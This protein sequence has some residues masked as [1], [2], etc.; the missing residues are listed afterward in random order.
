MMFNY[1]KLQELSNLTFITPFYYT[2]LQRHCTNNGVS[3]NKIWSKSQD[4][5]IGSGYGLYSSLLYGIFLFGYKFFHASVRIGKINCNLA[6][7]LWFPVVKK[8]YILSSKEGKQCI[9]NS[10]QAPTPVLHLQLLYIRDELKG[11][12]FVHIKREFLYLCLYTFLM[13]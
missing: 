11:I 8:T 10:F 2:L 1:W 7:F 6:S 5:N 3:L 9:K 4:F 13:G 12:Y